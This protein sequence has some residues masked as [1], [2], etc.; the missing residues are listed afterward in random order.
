MNSTPEALCSLPITICCPFPKV[1]TSLP[2]NA[3][4]WAL[5]TE[6]HCRYSLMTGFFTLHTVW[7]PNKLQIAVVHSFS[8][9][10][11]IPLYNC[12]VIY[13]AYLL[14]LHIPTPPPPQFL[15]LWV[16]LFWKF[17]NI[18]FGVHKHALLL[19]IHEVKSS[20][21]V[22]EYLQMLDDANVFQH[23]CVHLYSLTV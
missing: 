23:S 16:I 8:L 18:S 13:F 6:N 22:T 2:S 10:Y 7:D 17:L 9:L 15:L 3:W 1:Y 14:M 20:C 19:S 11:K 4:F 12:T 5:C 21:G